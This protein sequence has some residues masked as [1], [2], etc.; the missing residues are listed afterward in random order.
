MLSRIERGPDLGTDWVHHGTF[1]EDTIHSTKFNQ[2]HSVLRGALRWA[3]TEMVTV[4][5][6]RWREPEQ[7]PGMCYVSLRRHFFFNHGL[8]SN[9]LLALLGSNA[10]IRSPLC[11]FHY[12]G[13]QLYVQGLCHSL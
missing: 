11:Y 6:S 10:T 4:N 2:I 12:L 3:R 1:S 13:L 7:D 5:G 8:Q 9:R